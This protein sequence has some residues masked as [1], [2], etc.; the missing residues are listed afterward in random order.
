MRSIPISA[1]H[2]D[3]ACRHVRP[4]GMDQHVRILADQADIAWLGDEARM[5]IL[6]QCRAQ[7]AEFIDVFAKEVLA[8]FK[9]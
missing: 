5:G 3:D 4:E 6:A 7:Q 2:F 1:G 9:T 8:A